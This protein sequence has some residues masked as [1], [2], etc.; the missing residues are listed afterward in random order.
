M[1]TWHWELLNRWCVCLWGVEHNFKM[2]WDIFEATNFPF[3]VDSPLIRAPSCLFLCTRNQVALDTPQ[4]FNNESVFLLPQVC[5]ITSTLICC[6]EQR[7]DPTC[8][9]A[10]MYWR[11]FIIEWHLS[12]FA[13]EHFRIDGREC[14]RFTGLTNH[15]PDTH[16]R[17]GQLIYVLFD[18]DIL[19]IKYVRED[20][21]PRIIWINGT[22]IGTNSSPLDVRLYGIYCCMVW[23]TIN[24]VTNTLL[25]TYDEVTGE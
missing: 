20:M 1:W 25:M 10:E 8:W 5:R 23:Q 9:H 24:Q 7:T 15:I 4:Q 21:V 19:R 12:K 22:R 13:N 16:P 17:R 3:F 2:K 6:F 14:A 11:V 18:P